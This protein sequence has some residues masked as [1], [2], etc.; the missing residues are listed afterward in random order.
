MKSYHRYSLFFT[1]LLIAIAG[2]L[3]FRRNVESNDFATLSIVLGTLAL[4][5]ILLGNSLITTVL[6]RYL[7]W[8]KYKGIRFVS[9]LILGLLF[10]LICI[11]GL[12]VMLKDLYTET[13]PDAGQILTINVLSAA[14]IIPTITV[15]FGI[16]FLR[17][18]NASQVEAERLQKENARS[19]MMSLRNHLDPHFLFNNLNILSS[20]IDHDIN[21]SKEYLNK[22]AEVY[23]T[24][25]KSELSDLTT[26]A[27][28]MKLV[29]AYIYLV[30]IRW[31][32]ALHITINIDDKDLDK[33]LPPL[34]AQMLIE[35]VIK[36]N[37]ISS[38]QSMQ[39]D[40]SSDGD[41]LIITND[42]RI[43]KYDTQTRKGTGLENIQ[44]R[45]KFFTEKEVK[46]IN[47]DAQ[48]SV[49]LP[50]LTVE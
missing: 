43:K 5:L 34:S 30:K 1:L 31:R 33:A 21:L 9:Q 22:F 19:Q 6:D 35:N 47:G 42:K 4:S 20:L 50:L 44:N 12:Y 32:E 38:S 48:F 37:T 36:H 39:I 25:L 46:I 26:L 17:A 49:Y 29:D 41:Y 13:A 45:Y 11:N 7:P 28:E 27:E 2:F 14:I 10:S 15:F 16:K 23:R 18:W 8:I 40:I 3:L 24:I